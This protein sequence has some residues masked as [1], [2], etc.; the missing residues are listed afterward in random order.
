M[1]QLIAS[2]LVIWMTI[3]PTHAFASLDTLDD[4]TY[5]LDYTVLHA[6]SGSASIANDYF[7]KPAL[8]RVDGNERTIQLT[9]NHSEWTKELQAPDGDAFTDVRIVRDD[10]ATDTTVVQFPIDRSLDEPLPMKMHV[11]IETMDP[12][13]DHRYT[14]RLDFDEASATAAD[15]RAFETAETD[16]L[17]TTEEDVDS[18]S[19]GPSGFITSLILI[20]I[21]GT[22]VYFMM[23]QRKEKTS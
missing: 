23:S 4:G 10:R 13:Y 8:L 7:E 9:L 15:E 21:V 17:V 2:I 19:S 1:R 16:E 22:G 18:E 12:V 14:V 20:L 3:I 11:L 5:E 6:D